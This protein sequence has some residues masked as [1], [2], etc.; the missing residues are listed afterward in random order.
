M[1]GDTNH[2]LRAEQ[3]AR[4]RIGAVILADMHAVTAGF[5][6]QIGAVIHQHWHA[7]GMGH[8][9]N[10]VGGRADDVVINLFQAQLQTGHRPAIQGGG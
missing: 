1:T 3:G 6:G 10:R 4:R 8:R 5:G 9:H 2:R 7:A